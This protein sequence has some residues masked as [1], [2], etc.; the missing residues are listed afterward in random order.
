MTALVYRDLRRLAAHYLSREAR[1]HTLQPTALV[2]EA[3][4]HLASVRGFDWKAKGQFIA[5]VAQMMRRILVD[6]ARRRKAAKRAAG[7]VVNVTVNTLDIAADA[8][9]RLDVLL[10]DQVLSRMAETY[11]RHADSV[12]L[13]FFGGLTSP[14]IAKV[15]N[16]SVAT[17]ERDWRFAKAWLHAEMSRSS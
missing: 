11:P 14:E 9:S 12:E 7:T 8:P 16:I 6:H 17:V 2:H 3:Y 15:L 13:R 4:L 5:V 10:V 1:D